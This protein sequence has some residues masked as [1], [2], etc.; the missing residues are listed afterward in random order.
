MIHEVGHT[1]G[2]PH[3]FKAS[4][5]YTVEQL[6]DPEWTKK[7]GTAPSIMDYARFNYVAQPGDGA[8]LIPAIGP[9]DLYSIDWGYRQ[10]PSNAD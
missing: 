1:L 5:S 2:L 4:N 3:N 8:A 6:R 10:F 9:Y 7:N